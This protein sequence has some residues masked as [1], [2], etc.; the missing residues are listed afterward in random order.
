M[1]Q[2]PASDEA[3]CPTSKAD[4]VFPDDLSEW[5]LPERLVRRDEG[6]GVA[7]HHETA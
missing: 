3:V 1:V 4:R 7:R 5:V 6:P 2:R